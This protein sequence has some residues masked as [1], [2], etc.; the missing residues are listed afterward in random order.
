M[1]KTLKLFTIL[2]A[3][4]LVFSACKKDEDEGTSKGK[5]GLKSAAANLEKIMYIKDYDEDD[6]F[7]VLFLGGF[8]V[9]GTV[10]VEA[11]EYNWGKPA[12]YTSLTQI[13]NIRAT[14]IGDNREF[15]S[16]CAYGWSSSYG[17]D[18]FPYQKE[19][20]NGGNQE[21]ADNIIAA[22]NYIMAEYG[23]ID[24]WLGP[25]GTYGAWEGPFE[26]WQGDGHYPAKNYVYNYTR[27]VSQIVVWLL[28]HPDRIESIKVTSFEWLEP[29]FAT[30]VNDV[31]DNYKRANLKTPIVQLAYLSCDGNSEHHDVQPQ[32]LP[33]W[34]ENPPPPP[35]LGPAYGSVT[36]TNTD[37][38]NRLFLNPKNGNP[39]DEKDAT[40]KGSQNFSYGTEGRVVYN[41]NHFTYAKFTR[42][43]LEAGVELAMVVGNKFQ[44]VG[45]ATAQIVDGNIVVEIEKFGAGSFGVMAFNT[46]MTAKMP[47][48]GNIHSQKEADLM[49]ELGATTGFNHNNKLV[50][51]CPDGNVIYLYIHCGT[52]QFWQ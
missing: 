32:I 14:R 48:N 2:L 35:V 37:Y 50:V 25:I 23:S 38:M 22:L 31:M 3:L 1:K 36:A 51:P 28:M 47:K 8:D 16:F 15:T 11:T 10:F 30:A 18:E 26:E 34:G 29:I 27:V 13:H 41:S 5:G 33:I 49:K 45:K 42:A 17:N 6:K 19:L 43:E 9:D 39:T 44:Y 12:H 20:L 4:G 7:K 52:I 21:K 46:A 40:P 24:N